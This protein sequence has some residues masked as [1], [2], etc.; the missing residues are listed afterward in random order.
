[1]ARKTSVAMTSTKAIVKPHLRYC[2][3]GSNGV[4]KD[5]SSAQVV[6][7]RIQE[8]ID[9]LGRNL[10]PEELVEEARNPISPV[11]HEFEWDRDKLAYE[12]LKARARQ[13]IATVVVFQRDNEVLKT[14][15]R[16]FVTMGSVKDGTK[17]YASLIT[18]LSDEEMRA[19]LLQR[20]YK[21]LMAFEQ[22]YHELVEFA[23]LFTVIR[24]TARKIKRHIDK[25][26]GRDDTRPSA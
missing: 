23:D 9:G 13:I 12:A 17:G 11:H 22:R 2:W 21:E 3:K 16:A 25:G 20:A 5:E 24:R 26:K 7:E 6:G 8:M 18:V 15:H 19:Q 10:E 1:M 14:P 4:F